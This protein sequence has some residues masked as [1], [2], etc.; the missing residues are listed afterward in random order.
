MSLG[1]SQANG[2]SFGN[3]L[4]GRLNDFRMYDSCLSA[5][6]IRE[7][8]RGLVLHYRFDNSVN[9][10]AT[11]VKDT[12]GYNRDGTVIGTLNYTTDSSARYQIMGS[13]NNT[14]T[15]NH[16]EVD[17]IPTPD[18]ELSISFWVKSAKTTN[19]V[20]VAGPEM[21]IGTLNSLMYVNPV[22]SPGFTTAN[23]KNNE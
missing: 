11:I 3:Y 17:D 13:M 10:V 14:S 8:A 7:I 19:Q 22:S 4:T 1:C 16:I 15:T 12:S 5:K 23:F 20:F 6:E 9:T 21:V 18:G 2:Q